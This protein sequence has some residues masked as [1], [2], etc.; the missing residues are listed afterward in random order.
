MARHKG[1]P[2]HTAVIGPRRFEMLVK[3]LRLLRPKAAEA[4]ERIRVYV[5]YTQVETRFQN[6]EEAAML[7]EEGIS[8]PVYADYFPRIVRYALEHGFGK[9]ACPARP[10][11]PSAVS[12]ATNWAR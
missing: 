6:V 2:T 1:K 11:V 5:P 7:Q 4:L 12:S 10:M 8:K 9:R 3:S